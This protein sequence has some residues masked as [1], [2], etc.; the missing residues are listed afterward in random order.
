MMENLLY[1]GDNLDVL[2]HRIADE[3]VDLVY[4]DP[5][6]NSRRS[7]AVRPT[8]RDGL[9]AQVHVEAFDD[10]WRWDEDAA[11][12]YDDL[13]EAGPERVAQAMRGFRTLV[14][15]TDLLAYLTMMAPRLVELRRVLKPNGSLYLH[16]DP[17]ASAALRLLLEAVFGNEQFRNEIVWHYTGG[18]RSKRYFSRKHDVI[19]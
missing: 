12:A 15:E 8:G 11:A 13:L 2:R 14:G 4:L 6:F 10:T 9:R 19:F 17:G 16:C 1:L 7:Y 3:S 5:P 18:G